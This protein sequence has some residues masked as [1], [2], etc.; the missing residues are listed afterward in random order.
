MLFH[1]QAR[2]AQITAYSSLLAMYL[3]STRF[4][5]I[6]DAAEGLSPVL[7]PSASQYP[8]KSETS[9]RSQTCL[10]MKYKS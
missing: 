5:W 10:N 9:A 1:P 7:M 8:A 3:T 2:L 4:L 6:I